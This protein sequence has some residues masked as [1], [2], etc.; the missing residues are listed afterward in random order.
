VTNSII[1]DNDTVFLGGRGGGIY[2][3]GGS[4]TVVG[5]TIRKNY[6][7]HGGGIYL[8]TPTLR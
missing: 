2:A 5:T 6:A 8:A 1:E 7:G 4:L 3:D